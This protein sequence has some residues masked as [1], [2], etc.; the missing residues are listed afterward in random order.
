[1]TR[2]VCT[3][4]IFFT[5]LVTPVCGQTALKPPDL[6]ALARAGQ[7]SLK[8]F[9]KEAASW[10]T[11]NLAPGGVKFV[12]DVIATPTMRRS[13]LSVEVQNRRQE[14]ARIT[15]KGG[16]WY[17]N[18]GGKAGKYRPFEAPLDAPTAYIYLTRSAPQFITQALAAGFGV[19]EGTTKGIATYRSPLADHLKKAAC[20]QHR[21]VR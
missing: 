4:G 21:R 11:T 9:D 8:R 12:V 2:P 6:A 10:T 15:Q 17:V 3:I 7:A 13:V 1:M 18:E 14:L 5:A 16:I 20:E 19:Y